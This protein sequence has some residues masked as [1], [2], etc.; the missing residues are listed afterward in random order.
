M[1]NEFVFFISFSISSLDRCS[2]P[3]REV[4][5][6]WSYLD[7]TLLFSSYVYLV[8][9][10]FL[11]HSFFK[12]VVLTS[13]V[14]P[15]KQDRQNVR[16]KRLDPEVVGFHLSLH[17]S[18]PEEPLKKNASEACCLQAFSL[19]KG[20]TGQSTVVFFLPHHGPGMQGRRSP[21]MVPVVEGRQ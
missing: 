9:F 19:L 1:H 10:S 4:S 17:L 18:L 20:I 15:L 8:F 14:N 13:G 16:D 7:I 11:F 21:L 2:I 12:G 5:I 3:S 6:L